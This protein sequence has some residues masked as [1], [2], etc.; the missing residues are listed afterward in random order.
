LSA[1]IVVF[2]RSKG[3][4]MGISQEEAVVRIVESANEA[5]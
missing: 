1:D 5:Y 2:A 3:A 4:F